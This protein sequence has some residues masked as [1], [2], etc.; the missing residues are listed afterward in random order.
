MTARRLFKSKKQEM[1]ALAAARAAEAKRQAEE[2]KRREEEAR[3]A[4]DIARR[5]SK[6]L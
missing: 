6:R 4:A 3:L 2:A 5:E 1:L